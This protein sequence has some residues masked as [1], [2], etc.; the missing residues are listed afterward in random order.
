[1]TSCNWGS[2]KNHWDWNT[3]FV[4]TPSDAGEDDCLESAS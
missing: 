4:R 2:N 3:V 1:M